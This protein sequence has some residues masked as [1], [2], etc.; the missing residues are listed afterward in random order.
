MKQKAPLAVAS[1][2]FNVVIP[3]TQHNIDLIA[4]HVGDIERY[5]GPSWRWSEIALWI[6]ARSRAN[7]PPYMVVWA[8]DYL[9][10][11]RRQE[12]MG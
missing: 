12:A 11:R 8:Y 9:R 2:T 10:T 4:Q 7:L 6:E 3:K 5:F 1:I